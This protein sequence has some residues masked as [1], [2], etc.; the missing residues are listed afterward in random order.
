M[1]HETRWLTAV[2]SALVLA[3]CA[4][5]S[6]PT[7]HGPAPEARPPE[8]AASGGAVESAVYPVELVFSHRREIELDE[9]QSIAIRAELR[10]TQG[11]LASAEGRLRRETVALATA[12]RAT[13][14][15]EATAIA[16][17]ERVARSEGELKLA[18]LRLLVRVKNLLR[19]P[20]RARLDA[21]RRPA[22]ASVP[23]AR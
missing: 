6:A 17:A 22:R 4:E 19:A 5:R 18:H 21:L 8:P 12:L 2:A 10:R 14:V 20:Q 9:A 7:P 1:R 23:A 3:A 15:D 11:E 16:A 13:P